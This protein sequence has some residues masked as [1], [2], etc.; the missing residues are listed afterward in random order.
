[1]SILPR[2]A[3][4]A[5]L[6]AAAAGTACS[7]AVQS[8]HASV[9][10]SAPARATTPAEQ[11]RADSGRM[12]FT[13]ADVHFMQGM[14]HHHAQA[15][16]MAGWAQT[17]NA[18]SDVKNLAQ[19]IDVGQRDEMAFMQRWLRER[20]QE[21]PDPLAHYEMGHDM[22]D[23]KMEMMPGMLTPEQMKQLDAARG[24]EFDRLFLTYMI[25]HHQGAITMVDQLFASP[26]AGQ[27]L[28]V[29]RFASDVN[30]DQTTEIDRMRLMLGANTR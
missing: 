16:V 26:G 23:M 1:M 9:Q 17:H 4:V 8:A 19:R 18:R 14:I 5:S 20:H 2:L 6:V 27:E 12:P 15:V 7:S 21:V 25:Q 13:A 10:S 24:P 3:G 30:A 22:G 28:Y 29:F 11:A